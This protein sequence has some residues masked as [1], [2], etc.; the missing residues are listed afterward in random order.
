MAVIFNKPEEAQLIILRHVVKQIHEIEP[1]QRVAVRLVEG[2]D[3]AGI[4]RL[5]FHH[6]HV[7]MPL[8]I[9]A[10]VE[11]ISHAAR[12]TGR[13]VAPRRP[14]NHDATARHVFAA[15]IAGAFYNGDGARVADGEPLASHAAEIA[16]A[17]NRTVKDGIADNDAFLRHD[18][19]AIRRPN[20]D[21]A[22]GKAL[23][24][25]VIGF[26]REIHR[27][28]PCKPGA[29]ALS[30]CTLEGDPDR[31]F[32][33]SG[34]TVGFRHPARQHRARGAVA[35]RDGQF[36]FYR[37]CRFKRRLG[38]FD[39]LAVQYMRDGMILLLRVMDRDRIRH[40]RLVE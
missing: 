19:G 17:G 13:E 21:S 35:A 6:R 5:K 2:R 4:N 34:M 25:V 26:A 27:D 37:P 9:A 30:R 22:A 20:D 18:G 28:A 14:E 16:L 24:D 8:E 10:L 39:Q 11:H 32:G 15:M 7:A 36:E 3:I 40:L 23:A 38:A 1:L 31:V 12:H 33:K 29:K